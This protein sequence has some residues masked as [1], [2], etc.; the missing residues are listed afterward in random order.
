MEQVLFPTA[1]FPLRTQQWSF[2][3]SERA[4]RGKCLGTAWETE[5]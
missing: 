3:H 1:V 4:R 2:L 5:L